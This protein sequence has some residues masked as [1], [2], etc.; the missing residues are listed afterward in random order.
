LSHAPAEAPPR[1]GDAARDAAAPAA[2][3]L[4]PAAI[5]GWLARHPRRVLAALAGAAAFVRLILCLQVAATPLAR[6]D[7]LVRDSDSHFFDAWGRRIAGGELLQPAPFHPMTGWM[8]QIAAL[9][10]SIDPQLPARLGVAAGPGDDRAALEERLWDRWLGGATFYQEPAYPY[11]IGLT[12][13]LGGPRP[14]HVFAWQLVI[15]VLGVLLVHRLARRLFSETAAA[16]AGALAVLA[17]I[18]LFFEVTLLRDGLVAVVTVALALAMHWTAEGGRRRWFLLG[19]AFG[20]ASLL[21]A[22]FLLFPPLLAAWRLATVRSPARDRLAAAAL[23]AGGMALALL[24]AVLRN[25]AVG[26][27]PLALNGSASG[28]LAVYHTANASPVWLTVSSEFAR[29]LA[30]AG[31]RQLASLVEAA[32]THGSLWSLASLELQKLL[33]AWHGFESPNNV[34]FYVFRQGVPLLASLPATFVAI[35]PLAAVGAATRRAANAWPLLVAILG[36]LSTLVLAAT[37]SRYRAPLTMALL[38]LAGAGVA[39]LAGWLKARRWI[40]IGGAAAASALYVAWA[41]G[42]PPGRTRPALAQRYA[43]LG[44]EWIG[45]GQPVL[46]ALHLQEALRLEPAA[47]Q[48]EAQLGE[49]LLLSRDAEAALPH[50]EAAA[51]ALDS[52][53]LRE[54]RARTLAELGRREEAIAQARAALAADPGRAGARALLEALERTGAG[55]AKRGP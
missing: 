18:P 5:E 11:L 23:T 49:A 21:K 6:I 24:P 41:T 46:A 13:A 30:N 44:A 17:P 25:L 27:P 20:A 8:R 29:V 37:L 14:W 43:K 15:G 42:M 32:R 53:A 54:L 12:Y 50:V 10:L 38:P 4:P 9:A 3:D 1:G 19:L 28:M 48:T 34:D 47:P 33:Y 2:A 35:L 36:S 40:W 51:R 16:A 26:V 55:E 22:S 45:M 52:P 39:R 7:E 31:G